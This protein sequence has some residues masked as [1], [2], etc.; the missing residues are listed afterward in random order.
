MK[1]SKTAPKSSNPKSETSF[2]SKGNTPSADPFFSPQAPQ[3]QSQP[4][5]PPAIQRKLDRDEYKMARLAGGKAF[6]SEEYKKYPQG[7]QNRQ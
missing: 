6:R 1:Q 5:Q 7:D 4:A 2:F 3:T